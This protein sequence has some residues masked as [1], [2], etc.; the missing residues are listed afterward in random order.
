MTIAYIDS[1]RNNYFIYIRVKTT[2]VHYGFSIFEDIN[3]LISDV[4]F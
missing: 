3:T 4:R 1:Y 2:D